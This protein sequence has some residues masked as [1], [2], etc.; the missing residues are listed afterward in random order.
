MSADFPEVVRIDALGDD[1]SLA[2]VV[3]L[4]LSASVMMIV[5]SLGL[6]ATT[7]DATYLFRQPRRLLKSLASMFIIT[8]V[9]A[10]VLVQ[11]LELPLAVEITM[12]VIA[13]S[14]VPPI[15]P[16]K[17][18][19][20]GGV[21]SYALGLLVA[22]A[23]ISVLFVPA[24]VELFEK[25]F[26]RPAEM[27]PF[28]IARIVISSVIGPLAVGL[29]VRHFWPGL[30]ER[31]AAPLSHL[32]TLL[33]IAALLPVQFTVVS[34]E[35]SLIGHGTLLVLT[36][37]V[38]I[39]LVAGALLGGPELSDRIVLALS[40]ASRHPGVAMAIVS[41]NRPNQ[42]LVLPAILLYLTVSTIVSG[43]F[44]VWL[45]RRNRANEVDNRQSPAA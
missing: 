12:I 25:I 35:I 1:M 38:V 11:A 26:K 14:P 16:K 8:P 41:A 24:A 2:R 31:S 5:F 13:M 7:H 32:A 22:A 23:V 42:K 6:Q 27:S 37:F 33:L 40:T 3:Q 30:A 20:A 45:R 29:A 18:L 34:A 28:T 15:L 19:A 17:E 39:C 44:V 10:A 9:V 4:V 36:V 43:V 21:R